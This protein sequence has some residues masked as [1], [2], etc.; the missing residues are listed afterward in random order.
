MRRCTPDRRRAAQSTIDRCRL[1][2]DLDKAGDLFC[3][4]SRGGVRVRPIAFADWIEWFRALLPQEV[5]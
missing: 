5:P 4:L 1:P 3:A 2:V